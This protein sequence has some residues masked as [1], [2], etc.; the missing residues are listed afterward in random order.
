MIADV[1]AMFHEIKVYSIYV[2]A[3]HFLWRENGDLNKK[4]IICQMIVHLF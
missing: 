1:E 4:P 2:D 3:V